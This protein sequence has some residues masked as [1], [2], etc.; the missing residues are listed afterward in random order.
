MLKKTPE[1][2]RKQYTVPIKIRKEGDVFFEDLEK[3]Q[4]IPKWYAN[5]V[6]P[7][8]LIKKR[9]GELRLVIDYRELNS[10][11]IAQKYPIPKIRDQLAQLEGSKF[12][13]QIHLKSGYYQIHMTPQD[14]KRHICNSK[15]N[16]PPRKN[17]L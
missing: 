17:A 6:S 16:L 14:K 13:S 12:F 7:A 11:T 15:S 1:G 3:Q 4:I 8:F 9:N 10:C 5:F 2:K